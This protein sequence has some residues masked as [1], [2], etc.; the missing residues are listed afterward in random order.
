M[1]TRVLLA[2]VTAALA[3]PGMAQ[4]A[5]QTLARPHLY[6]PNP[7]F[8]SIPLD[9]IKPLPTPSGG[10]AIMPPLSE[11]A[12]RA[13]VLDQ[14]RL[15]Y[16]LLDD[17]GGFIPAPIGKLALSSG[18]R[19]I[20]GARGKAQIP[21]YQHHAGGKVNAFTFIGGPGTPVGPGDN[22]KQPVPGL[23]VPV[24][25]P[26]ATNSNNV[27]PANQ[28]FAGNGQNGNT[29]KPGTGRP[30]TQGQGTTSGP[31][32]AGTGRGPGTGHGGT[33]T[34]S[35]TGAGHTG[36]RP[37]TTRQTTSAPTTTHQ[38]TTQATVST[39]SRTTTASQTTT[40]TP[41]T[42]TTGGG[43]GGGG[44]SGDCGGDGISIQTDPLH[45][46]CVIEL[47]NAKPGDEEHEVLKI[48][49]SSTTPYTLALKAEGTHNHL[50][51]DLEMGVWVASTP[52]PNP[53]PPLSFWTTQYNDL[54]VTLNP[55]QSV[56]LRIQLYLPV[57][58]GN[59]DMSLTAVIDFKWLG[60]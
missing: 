17:L 51:D 36:S 41:T 34:Q 43:G 52:A 16:K 29:G 57:E 56:R 12:T 9:Y 1:R 19:E 22:G 42:T 2:A 46:G 60:H 28:G 53:L 58:A 47:Y 21:L 14:Q 48:T 24:A 40:T 45:P 4:A 38:T 5:A 27:P 18:G 15:A 49:N 30:G 11:A 37:T 26:P 44:G 32:G 50:W 55:G 59:A 23:G 33:T 54:P 25:V 6:R 8:T 35:G 7:T 10:V 3:T 13:A 39:T 31:G 20:V